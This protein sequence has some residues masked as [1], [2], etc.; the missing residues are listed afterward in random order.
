LDDKTIIELFRQRSE[1]ALAEVSAKFGGYCRRIAVNILR[2]PEDADECVNET[3]LRAWNAIPPA[4]P[5]KLTAFL[6]R[7]TRNLALDRYEATRAQKRG[8]SEVELA[9]EELADIA[10]PEKSDEGEITRVINSFL[11]GE[12]PEHRNIFLK[13]YLCLCSIKDIAAEYSYSESK[14]KSL[15]LRVRN[16]LKVKLESEG[17][18]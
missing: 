18:L 14:V 6:G 5:G 1:D 2:S 10:A 11:R 15:L 3:W 8:G 7:I 16:R 17:L 9:L 13:R 4:H 12:P